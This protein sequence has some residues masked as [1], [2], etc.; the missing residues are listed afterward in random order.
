MICVC[1]RRACGMTRILDAGFMRVSR[2]AVCIRQ[3]W[4]WHVSRHEKISDVYGVIG[5]DV[6][7][8]ALYT[9]LR[10]PLFFSLELG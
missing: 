9:Q 4:D 8:S 1:K 6:L 3:E 7:A 2:M 5:G 10:S